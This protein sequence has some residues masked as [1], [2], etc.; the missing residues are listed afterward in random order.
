MIELAMKTMTDD[1]RIGISSDDRPVMIGSCARDLGRCSWYFRALAGDALPAAIAQHEHVHVA[2]RQ[3]EAL[4]LAGADEVLRH[5]DDGGVAVDFDDEVV[6]RGRV[7]LLVETG[8]A[9]QF[10]G[11]VAAGAV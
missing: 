4:S 2:E 9:A 10:F 11:L 6:E 3:F 7:D 5:P 1:N 8:G